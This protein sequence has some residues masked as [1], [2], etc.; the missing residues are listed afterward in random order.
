MPG[1]MSPT[2]HTRLHRAFIENTFNYSQLAKRAI[3]APMGGSFGDYGTPASTDFERNNSLFIRAS[4]TENVGS[5]RK[6]IWLE[7]KVCSF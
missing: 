5:I 2:Y 3:L 7:C 1:S 6:I 4:Y